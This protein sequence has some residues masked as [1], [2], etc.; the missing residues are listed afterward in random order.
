MLLSFVLW[1]FWPLTFI[2]IGSAAMACRMAAGYFA[3]SVGCHHRVAACCGWGV[4]TK[5]C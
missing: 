2:G 1:G 5:T 3:L 4:A